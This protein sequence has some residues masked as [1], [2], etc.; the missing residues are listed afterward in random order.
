MRV[1][2]GPH[3]QFVIARLRRHSPR[4]GDIPPGQCGGLDDV[5]EVDTPLASKGQF[6]PP[7]SRCLRPLS[8]LLGIKDLIFMQRC[9]PRS[10]PA[11][12]VAVATRPAPRSRRRRGRLARCCRRA[13]P[14]CALHPC[15]FPL[16]RPR[17]PRRRDG[18]TLSPACTN[19]A[20][21]CCPRLRPRYPAQRCMP[22][23]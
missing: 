2:S 12:H 4:L 23:L 15:L 21:A 18:A 14:Q 17:G 6:G 11:Q 9:P 10:G 16:R 1:V 22:I 20:G 19:Q 8:V 5:T 3:T 13:T 7:R